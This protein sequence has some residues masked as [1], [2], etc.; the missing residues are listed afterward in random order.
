MIKNWVEIPNGGCE[1][2]HGVSSGCVVSVRYLSA[3]VL[4][5]F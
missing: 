2:L 5:T 1:D 4:Q 3:E